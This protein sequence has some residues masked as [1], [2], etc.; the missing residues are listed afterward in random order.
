MYQLVNFPKKERVNA[1]HT[2]CHSKLF[3]PQRMGVIPSAAV[4][5]AERETHAELKP[6]LCFHSELYP[7]SRPVR[8]P[9]HAVLEFL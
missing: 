4:F 1:T 7:H 9:L 6:S 2:L 3:R 8:F 5:P